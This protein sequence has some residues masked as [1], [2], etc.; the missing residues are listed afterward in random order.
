M[1]TFDS[2]K[3][4]DA[5]KTALVKY[6]YCEPTIIQLAQHVGFND[7]E[8]RM[9][10]VFW[11]PV[12]NKSWIFLDR[13][14]IQKWF[15]KNDTSK[16]AVS[17]FYN[18][19]LFKYN[20]DI[21]YKQI[22]LSQLEVVTSNS[23]ETPIV[24]KTKDN[25]GGR[26][27]KYYQVTGECFKMVAME[28]NKDIRLYYIK[29]EELA[30]FMKDYI[31]A[32]CQHINVEKEHGLLNE[33]KLAEQKEL[34]EAA[35]KKVN[36]MKI[37]NDTIQ[38]RI[39]NTNAFD[40]N[41]TFYIATSTRYAQQHIF[42]PGCVNS[43]GIKSL[44]S[45]LAQYNT[46]KTGDDLFYFCHIVEVYDARTLDYKLKKLMAQL[47]FNKN[48]E[49]VVLHYDS[50]IKIV[51]YVYERH[52]ESYETWNDFVTSG[53]YKLQMFYPAVIPADMLAN[54]SEQKDGE[55]YATKTIDVADLTNVQ[56]K[57]YLI[58][59]IEIFCTDN[60]IEYNH[61]ADKDNVDKKITIIWKD[62][63]PILKKICCVKNL[64]PS[65]WR[66]QLK[67]IDTDSKSINQIKW[68]KKN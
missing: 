62:L 20:E 30:V 64:Q 39:N 21:D 32:M 33:L 54:M 40:K 65:K 27:A 56:K 6:D 46:G 13:D 25:R 9:L 60:N 23:C 51:N 36:D 16:Y 59:A 2:I 66:D 61:E 3:C 11:E 15:C 67:N 47:K 43:I 58:Q 14:I 57:D 38:N 44:K 41:S 31:H 52:V 1:T 7:D 37:I 45:R 29:V 8:I 50:L 28:R 35:D 26:N 48:K 42:K 63:Q 19:V 49:M 55:V 5:I 18:R 22:E 12:F 17:H 10:N 24:S 53:D 34:T 68:I 4:T